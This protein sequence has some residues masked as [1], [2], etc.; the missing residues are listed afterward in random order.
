MA[1]GLTACGGASGSALKA[2][3]DTIS[4]T[5]RLQRASMLLRGTR[6][7]LAEYAR[8]ENAPEAYEALV[9]EYL[10]SPAF[11][12]TVRQLVTEWLELD[13]APDSYPAGFPALGPLEGMGTH[14]LNTS[15]IQAAGRLAEHVVMEGRP[16]TELVTADYTMADRV[17]ATVWGLPY[18]EEAGGWQRTEYTDGRAV[19]G[20]LSDGFLFTR[21]PSTEG[22]RHR[23]R[24]SL[25]AGTFIC[26][27]YPNRPVVIPPDIDLT[28]EEAISNAVETNRVCQSCHHSMDPLASFFST[29]YALRF[30]AYE[31]SYPLV[32]YTPEAA[33]NFE[34]P[35]WYGQPASDLEDLGR[36]I[37]EDP[38]FSACMVRRFYS[39]MM[40][41]PL[42]SVPVEVIAPF[43]RDFRQGFDARAL[44]RAIVLSDEFAG[45][46]VIDG[47]G[48]PALRPPDVGLRKVTPQQL[49]SLVQELTGYQWR[50]TVPFELESGP[51][52]SVPLMRDPL[53]GYRTLAGGPN[54]FDT[55]THSR[56]M[57]AS[58][59]LVASALAERA[60]RHAVAE[61][62]ASLLT[63]DGAR[64]GTNDAVRTQ[65]RQ[66]H[67]RLFGERRD[68][69]VAA[70]EA[71]LDRAVTLFNTVRDACDVGRA[72]EVTLAALLQDPRL[73]MF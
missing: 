56:T 42:E 20:V 4:P 61:A 68:E 2:E 48:H 21:M 9:D 70:D 5:L 19:A 8:V 59:L 53:F 52:G 62:G 35:S 46:Q 30:P 37:A 6:P 26:H 1:G 64:E 58:T 66:L 11:G 51:I 60:A 33:A 54:G 7:T 13:Q 67:L 34:P 3:V 63:V 16:F 15:L 23:E 10:A 29:H 44:V 55:V 25:I 27:D 12:A 57:D 22:N 65:L 73:L 47:S 40:H 14:E 28:S 39:E 45:R 71:E 43:D 17:V 24:A 18:D 72:W 50:A 36:L 32:E 69:S 41:V 31:T 49:D 38:R